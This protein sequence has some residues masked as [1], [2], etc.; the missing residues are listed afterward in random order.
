MAEIPVKGAV[1]R[2]AREFRELSEEDAADRLGLAVEDLRAYEAGERK[3]SLT[4]FENIAAK[5]RL[6]QATLF[7]RTPPK[8]RPEPTDFRTLEGRKPNFSFDFR[9][10][11]SNV[12]SLLGMFA[13]VAE[14]DD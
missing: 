4:V 13:R 2:W 12:R 5:Y 14:D 10:A 1:L 8:L 7:R 9:V 6:P 11:L 3:P